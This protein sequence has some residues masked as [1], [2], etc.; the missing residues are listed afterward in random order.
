MSNVSACVWRNVTLSDEKIMVYVHA[1][2]VITQ[3]PAGFG[4][5][6]HGHAFGDGQLRA[7]SFARVS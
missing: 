1:F 3:N 2:G 6:D 7:S 4:R 5:K